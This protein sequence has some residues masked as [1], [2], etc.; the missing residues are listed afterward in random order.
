[1]DERSTRSFLQKMQQLSEEHEQLQTE[2]VTLE[3]VI[4]DD[5]VGLSLLQG[6]KRNTFLDLRDSY[7]RRIGS[8][9]RRLA[10]LQEEETTNRL[11]HQQL[12]LKLSE[13]QG[14]LQA[15]E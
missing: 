6:E 3:D 2:I 4:A 1:M 7:L 12:E 13:I 11:M 8:N 10:L 15:A 5:E 9:R 14:R